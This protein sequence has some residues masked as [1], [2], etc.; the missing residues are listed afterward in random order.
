MNPAPAPST[1]VMTIAA[2]AASDIA[3]V[4]ALAR[5]IWHRHYPGIITRAQIDYMLARGYNDEALGR[6][7]TTAGSGLALA[8][9]GDD[10]VGFVG[11]Y[12]L[13]AQPTMK[14]DKL[15]VLPEHHGAGFGRMLIEHVVARARDAG[16]CAVTLN[17]NRNNTNAVRAYERCGFTIRERGDFPIGQGFV[18]EDYVMVREVAA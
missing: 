7:L 10:P 16:C 14:L 18:M 12:R 17:V 6:Y 5:D 13:D 11:W 1:P 3:V 9:R 2:A 15:Y 4:Q 8:F